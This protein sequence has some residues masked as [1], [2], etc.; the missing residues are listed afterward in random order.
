MCGDAAYRKGSLVEKQANIYKARHTHFLH[1]Y[2][3][4]HGGCSL[5]TTHTISAQTIARNDELS[6]KIEDDKVF[7]A[8]LHVQVDVRLRMMYSPTIVSS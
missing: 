3:A 7:L 1:S 5:P 4:R 8:V 6:C 2:M